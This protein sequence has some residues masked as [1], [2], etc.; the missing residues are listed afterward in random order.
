MKCNTD[1]PECAKQERKDNLT[2]ENLHNLIE[3]DYK[4]YNIISNVNC[5]RKINIQAAC[6][7]YCSIFFRLPKHLVAQAVQ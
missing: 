4:I 5:I 3:T 2:I 6:T 7:V 1:R